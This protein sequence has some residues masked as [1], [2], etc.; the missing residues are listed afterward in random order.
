M[1]GHLLSASPSLLQV[2]GK[3]VGLDDE[4][5]RGWPMLVADHHVTSFLQVGTFLGL[6][7]MFC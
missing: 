6:A 7:V 4:A 2:M 5:V 1:H 3:T